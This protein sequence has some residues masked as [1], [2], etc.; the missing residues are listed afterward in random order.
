MKGREPWSFVRDGVVALRKKH[1]RGMRVTRLSPFGDADTVLLMDSTY[2]CLADTFEASA[3]DQAYP[4]SA[5]LVGALPHH[6]GYYNA[7]RSHTGFGG[8]TP[9]QKSGAIL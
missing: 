8:L 9:R 5:S 4:A 2:S 1:K 3:F 6:R 7:P